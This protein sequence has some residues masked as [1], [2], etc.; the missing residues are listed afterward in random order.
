MRISIR[1]QL[2]LLVLFTAL[3]S[4]MVLA[5]ATW[6]QNKAFIT[7]IRLSGLSLTASLKAAQIAST[8][9]LYESQI[10]AVATRLLIQSALQRYNAGSNVSAENWN[11]SYTD[12]QGALGNG[13]L[14]VQAVVFPGV[15]VGND[16][17]LSGLVNVTA[18]EM[19]NT[20][21]LPYLYPNG[22]E[23]LLGDPGAGYPPALYPN[24]TYGPNTS[25]SAA[26]EVSYNGRPLDPEE[27]LMLGP[28]IVNESYALLSGTLGI[29]N[30]T[31]PSFVLGWLTIVIDASMLFSIQESREGLGR[32]GEVLIVG[33]DRQ[34]N[35]FD[36]DPRNMS[37]EEAGEQQ[38]HFILPPINDQQRHQGRAS[39]LNSTTPF[40]MS[41][42]PAVV[43][44]WTRDNDQVNNA[45]AFI[46]TKNEDNHKVSAG[47]AVIN[48]S[49]ADWMLVV[50]Q[51]HGEVIAPINHLRDVVLICVFSVTGLLLLVMFP[52]AHYSITP[53]RQLRAATA[54][55]VEPYQPEDGS[56]YASSYGPNHSDGQDDAISPDTVD[57]KKDSFF[58]KFNLGGKSSNS[59]KK[60]RKRRTFRIPSKVPERK[61]WVTDELTELTST[62]NEMSDELAMQY[63]RLEERVRERTAE[64]ERSKKA[65]EAAN[66]SKTLFIANISHELKTPLNGILGLTTV[67]MN[68]DDVSKIRSTL[69]TIYKSGDLLLHLLTDLLT[70]SKN[71]VGQQLSIDKT[72]FRISDL[73]TQLMPT[74]EKQAREGQIDFKVYYLGTSDAF[75]NTSESA[76]ER[77]YGPHGTGRIRDMCLWGDKNRIL[78]VLMNFVSN[79]LKFTPPHGSVTV[80]IRC[81][82]MVQNQD[83][84]RAGSLRKSSVN[85]RKSKASTNKKVRMSDSSLAQRGYS[86]SDLSDTDKGGQ[87]GHSS[88]ARNGEESKL[89]INLPGG[90]AHITKIVERRRSASPPLLNTKDLAFEFEVED[91]GPGIPED[92]QQKIFEPFVQGDLGLSKKYG[93][94]GLGLSICAQLAALMG[95]QISLDSQV[96]QGS[97]F[98]M[99][100]PL[101]Y[102]SERSAS[103]ASSMN[104]T[105][106]KASSLVGVPLHNASD[107][108]LNRTVDQNSSSSSDLDASPEALADVPR[109]VGFTQPYVASETKQDTAKAKLK[110]MKKAETEAAKK[111]KKVRVLVAE[112]NPV[113]QE[114]VLRMLKLEDVY[115]VTIA[116]DGQ[117]AFDKVRD[118]MRHGHERFDLVFMDVQMPNVDGIQSTKLIRE[119]GFR[120]PI[121]ALTAFAEKSNEDECMASGMDYFLA[122]PIKRPA[123]KQVLKKYAPIPEEEGEGST[124]AVPRVNELRQ[125][126]TE[127]RNTSP[128]GLRNGTIATPKTE[129]A[130]QITHKDDGDISPLTSPTG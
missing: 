23:V 117:E 86:D 55:T 38:V 41:D 73:S 5:L 66:Q 100:I 15:N 16:T 89:S 104:R 85:S 49:F 67:C 110:E 102:V 10:H 63:E 94:T 60:L 46:T 71:E 105:H 33:P 91:T 58:G 118:S 127:S 126:R 11:R 4:L 114:V 39:S 53:I 52:M 77:L 26:S 3:L 113:N 101:R 80:R 8:L 99:S 18:A 61:H 128:A 125:N 65:A 31:D 122:K 92:Q 121:V 21:V 112:D 1:E 6:F 84:S 98:T 74:F 20:V 62:F 88:P 56:E 103:S 22:S 111:G 124:A 14:L 87:R 106:S 9:T 75:G 115:D 108:A 51:D 35:L 81:V 43:A 27:M 47:Y 95:G 69:S 24:L 25:D 59:N 28:V 42:Y 70:F 57:E 19:E 36:N 30:I 50:E 72:E 79:S 12:L 7:D 130:V 123:L 96:N 54:K 116:K 129:P 97:K 45:G 78:Q 93:G 32:S 2:G 90:T 82:G 120:A 119:M 13:N 83:Q 29:V 37:R 40:T 68:E 34:I 64:L 44:A 107:T 76:G 48:T 109:I 17:A